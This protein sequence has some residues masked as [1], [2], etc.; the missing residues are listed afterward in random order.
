MVGITMVFKTDS[1]GFSLKMHKTNCTF[2]FFLDKYIYINIIKFRSPCFLS[3][4][5]GHYEWF[6]SLKLSISHTLYYTVV[7]NHFLWKG[8]FLKFCAI[9]FRELVCYL[10]L[11]FKKDTLVCVRVSFGEFPEVKMSGAWNLKW[12]MQ[13][14]PFFS[15]KTKLFF[16]KQHSKKMLSWHSW[17][18]WKKSLP[19]HH[20]SRIFPVFFF[21][22][23][24]M[25]TLKPYLWTP[26]R[27]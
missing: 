27:S 25:L 12:L 15:R 6:A 17:N 10:P 19:F 14:F 9:F 24:T 1:W 5:S 8:L 3:K 2:W 18:F 13:T 22:K 11:C 7:D 23:N 21:R 20:P 26:M 16:P 4:S